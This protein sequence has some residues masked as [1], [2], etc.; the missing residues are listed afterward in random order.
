MPVSE[1]RTSV[2]IS[3]CVAYIRLCPECKPRWSMDPTKQVTF[4]AKKDCPTCK[5]YGV[6]LS[7]KPFPKEQ[8]SG[9]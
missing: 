1:K 7:S 3:Q 4:G 8:P 2:D 9:N 5:G 6:Q